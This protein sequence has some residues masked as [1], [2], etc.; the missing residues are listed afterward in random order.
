MI[1]PRRD[2]LTACLVIGFS[3]FIF[4]ELNI[5]ILFHLAEQFLFIFRHLVCFL[6]IC[7]G[8]SVLFVEDLLLINLYILLGV[9]ERIKLAELVAEADYENEEDEAQHAKGRLND[10]R[11]L[12][13]F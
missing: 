4:S 7:R 5:E 9:F 2:L 11:D 8:V 1:G 12:L 13:N 3:N 6:E 10:C